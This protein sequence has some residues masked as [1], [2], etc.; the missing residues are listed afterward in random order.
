VEKYVATLIPIMMPPIA[1]SFIKFCS[2]INSNSFAIT[3]SLLL[4]IVFSHKAYHLPVYYV[5]GYQK[6]GKY[7][8]ENP[9]GKSA[10]FYGTY[11]GSFMMG[12]RQHV[13]KDGPYILRGERVL[14]YR[15]WWGELKTKASAK[16]VHE[17][18]ELFDKYKVGYIIIEENMPSAK[19]YV[20]YVNLLNT[21]ENPIRLKKVFTSPISTNY[22]N[23]GSKLVIYKHNYSD[24]IYG[25]EKLLIPLPQQKNIMLNF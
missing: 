10:I 13:D 14:A 6:A 19:D 7:V 12:V 4:I 17:I 23:L 8:A 20:E 5:Q 9:H 21:L 18:K 3:T 15:L 16:S 11:D 22:A 25:A 24:K 1:Y 2:R